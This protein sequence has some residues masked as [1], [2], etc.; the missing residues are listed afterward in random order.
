MGNKL[1]E[2]SI[3]RAENMMTKI[4]MGQEQEVIEHI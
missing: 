2:E 3:L 4:M 1:G